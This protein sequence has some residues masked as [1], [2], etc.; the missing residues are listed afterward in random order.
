M[1]LLAAAMV[2]ACGVGTTPAATASMR[3]PLP[4]GLPPASVVKPP[5]AAALGPVAAAL[6]R[7]TAPAPSPTT[8]T[9]SHLPPGTYEVHLHAICNGEQGYHLAYLPNLFVGAGH[10]GQIHLP[11]RDFGRGWCVIVYSDAVHNIVL[12]TQPI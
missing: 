3:Q 10:T 9:F 5:I 1:L 2:V 11:A 6:S 7:P 8:V 12:T 4:A